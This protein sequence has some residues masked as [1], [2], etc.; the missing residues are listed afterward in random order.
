MSKSLTPAVKLTSTMEH[1][2]DLASAI[3][4]MEQQSNFNFIMAS[5]TLTQEEGQDIQSGFA[6][7]HPESKPKKQSHPH[8]LLVEDY[9]ANILVTTIL[10]EQFGCTTIVA[11]NGQEALDLVKQ[12]TFDLVFMD[13]EMPIMDGCTATRMIR[14]W[15]KEHSRK[16]HIIIGMTAHNQ[17]A[18]CKKCMVSGMNDYISKPFQSDT[19]WNQIKKYSKQDI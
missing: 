13:I 15:E 8:I 7:L 1:Q 2:D 6:V 12:N 11:Q 16:E 14:D 19:L 18:I 5:P 9:R 10:L 3:A 17:A 4:Q